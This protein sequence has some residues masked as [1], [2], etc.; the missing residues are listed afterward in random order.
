MEEL[1]KIDAGLSSPTL[2]DLVKQ[3]ENLLAALEDS[4]SSNIALE[5][6]TGDPESLE[7]SKKSDMKNP[8]EI[9]NSLEENSTHSEKSPVLNESK[10]IKDSTFGTPILKSSSPY[11]RLPNPDNFMKDVSPV[12][13]FENLPNSTGKYEQMTEVL[14]KVRNT[15]KNLQ[16][17]KS[18]C[19]SM[20]STNEICI[21][22]FLNVNIFCNCSKVFVWNFNPRKILIQLL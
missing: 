14:Q 17:C 10:A 5:D 20:I 15:M 2:K 22:I 19:I 11:S 1:K 9:E 16:N 4:S 6:T 12:I 3:K 13:N 8:S 7:K 21:E 18:W